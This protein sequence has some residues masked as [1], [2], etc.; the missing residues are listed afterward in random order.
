M[1]E[2]AISILWSLFASYGCKLNSFY[3]LAVVLLTLGGPTV[4]T[5]AASV[6]SFERDAKDISDLERIDGKCKESFKQWAPLIVL[7]P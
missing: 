7:R 5:I 4:S 3:G 6:T 2:T 1:T